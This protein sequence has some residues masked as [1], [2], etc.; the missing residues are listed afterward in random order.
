M[1]LVEAAA[2]IA[3][4]VR[5]RGVEVEAIEYEVAEHDSSTVVATVWF[6]EGGGDPLTLSIDLSAPVSGDY[7]ATKD[8]LTRV[9]LNA[10]P[11]LAVH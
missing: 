8:A 11:T 5:L 2:Q 3:T 4:A 6:V 7:H 10:L 1:R 9:L